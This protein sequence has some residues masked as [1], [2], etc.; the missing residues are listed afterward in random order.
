P[1]AARAYLISGAD[2]LER[3]RPRIRKLDRIGS[4]TAKLRVLGN[5]DR[6]GLA[7]G[8]HG[9]RNGDRAG[10]CI[11]FLD[12][13]ADAPA[14]FLQ[15]ALLALGQIGLLHDNGDGGQH[16]AAISSLPANQDPVPGLNIGSPNRT[17]CLQVSLARSGSK[18]ACRICKRDAYFIAVIRDQDQRIAADRLDGACCLRHRNLRKSAAAQHED[19]DQ[20]AKNA[21][22]RHMGA[23]HASASFNHAPENR[24]R[25]EL[26]NR[27][28]SGLILLRGP[29]PAQ[30]PPSLPS[31][32]EPLQ[33]TRTSGGD[34]AFVRQRIQLG[35]S[36][37]RFFRTRRS[38]YSIA[39]E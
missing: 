24:R 19:Q 38:V 18:Y 8:E 17:R 31:R 20:A 7:R 3:A 16:R 36:G 9:V 30:L 35:G 28:K 22:T 33:F 32:V 26:S 13:P 4:V 29:G 5:V 11:H 14:P 34:P 27:V 10:L 21:S 12:D 23:F 1:G 2:L 6:D 39:S 37:S 25:K 15:L